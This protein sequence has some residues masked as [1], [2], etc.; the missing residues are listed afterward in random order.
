MAPYRVRQFFAKV[1]KKVQHYRVDAL[2][3]DADAAAYKYYKRQEY[4]DFYNSSVAVM[5]R[6]M[7]R[8]A[9]RNRS[10]QSRLHIDYSD[11]KSPF[12]AS[13]NRLS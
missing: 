10:F 2:A 12:S 6:Y 1:L 8:E 3:G 13:F 4:Q 5:L 9:N 7:Q 11:Q